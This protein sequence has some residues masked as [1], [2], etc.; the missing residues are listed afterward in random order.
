MQPNVRNE[1][2][3]QQHII[4]N[5]VDSEPILADLSHAGLNVEWIEDLYNKHLDYKKVIPILIKWLPQIENPSV[6]EAIVRALSIPWAR[7]TEAST[8]L[9][10]EFRKSKNDFGLIWAIGN[11][12]SVVADDTVL[13]NIVELIK[14]KTYG[15]AREMLVVSLGNMK[16]TDVINI[17]IELLED[18]NLAG[19]AII[20]LGKLKCIEARSA[21][22]RFQTHPKSWI[23]REAKKAM[24]KIDKV[25]I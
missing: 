5:K 6:K 20:A 8:L 15:K 18:E 14:D 10:E 25:K 21:I 1:D 23:R 12:L 22:E 13:N 9:I 16:S 24:N 3:V 7:H 19:Y 2:N 4:K 11:A 17:L